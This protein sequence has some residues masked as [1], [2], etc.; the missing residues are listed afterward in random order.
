MM[1]TGLPATSLAATC[2][3][4][5]IVLAPPF[6]ARHGTRLRIS[7]ADF[8]T[9]LTLSIALPARPFCTDEFAGSTEATPVVAALALSEGAACAVSARAEI[10]S[11]ASAATDRAT[12]KAILWKRIEPKFLN[13]AGP[14]QCEP[15]RSR[16][17]TMRG[18][19][20]HGHV[21]QVQVRAKR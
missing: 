15:H 19:G 12:T 6:G 14:D 10:R 11:T 3:S 2:G 21:L 5:P 20:N 17:S 18:R 7:L 16:I 4:E 9:S 1:T 13:S 8:A